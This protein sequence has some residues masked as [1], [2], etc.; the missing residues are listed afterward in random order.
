VISL[1]HLGDFIGLCSGVDEAEIR[2]CL[3]GLY[4]GISLNKPLIWETDCVFVASFLAN[5]SLDRSPL[6]DLKK[7]ALGII[8]LLGNFKLTKINRRA[9][10]ALC[11]ICYYEQ[12]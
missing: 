10:S 1:S 5:E 12:L 2:A 3:A 11:G 8:R 4:F 9:N 7:E 6:V